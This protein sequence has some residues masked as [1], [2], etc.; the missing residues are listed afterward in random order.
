MYVRYSYFALLRAS[1]ENFFKS[2][3]II[4]I[5]IFRL[6]TY[7]FNLSTTND[8]K[9]MLTRSN[10]NLVTTKIV[11]ISKDNYDSIFT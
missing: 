9:D 1:K 4:I 11:F 8:R 3:R 2:P 7:V 6:L 5:N 10:A